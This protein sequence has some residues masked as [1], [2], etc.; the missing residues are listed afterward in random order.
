MYC[1][2]L[3]L[4]CLLIDLYQVYPRSFE[5]RCGNGPSGT[6]SLSAEVSLTTH[7]VIVDFDCNSTFPDSYSSSL[8]R[9]RNLLAS[10]RFPTTA[11]SLLES[12]ISS[13]FPQL[14]IF[15]A[16]TGPLYN[17]LRDLLCAWVVS[18]ADEG[19]G[20]VEG[21][22]KVGLLPMWHFLSY[23]SPIRI[24]GYGII[25]DAL[26]HRLVACYCSTSPVLRKRSS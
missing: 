12:D 22:A 11:L 15:H 25:L 17:D 10:Q 24:F 4:A 19:L 3:G 5:A 18:R 21:V 26:R 14:H 1:S 20:Y 6:G 9:A 2:F 7:L 23:L 16:Q 8:A 13:T